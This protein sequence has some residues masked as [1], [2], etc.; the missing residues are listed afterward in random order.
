MRLVPPLRPWSPAPL[1]AA[2]RTHPTPAPPMLILAVILLVLWALCVLAL[3]I[4]FAAVHL[5]VILAVIA[6]VVHFVRGARRS[7]V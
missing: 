1:D 3:K 7:T 2:R 4:T 5:L 6:L